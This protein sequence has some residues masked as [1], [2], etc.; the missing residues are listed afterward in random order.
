MDEKRTKEFKVLN[1]AYSALT[2]LVW[3]PACETFP[4]IIKGFVFDPTGP[5]R[6]KWL[7]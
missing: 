7:D 3:H 2:I 6:N 1:L 4:I 5:G